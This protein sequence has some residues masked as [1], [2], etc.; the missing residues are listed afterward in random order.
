MLEGYEGPKGPKRPKDPV[1]EE[2]REKGVYGGAI[3]E[4]AGRQDPH[5]SRGQAAARSDGLE[6]AGAKNLFNINKDMAMERL[7]KNNPF[8]EPESGLRKRR[9]MGGNLGGLFAR[10][11][12]RHW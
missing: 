9:W 10:A 2:V 8:F 1:V 5:Q 11:G 3:R 4:E 7:W 6:P 12:V